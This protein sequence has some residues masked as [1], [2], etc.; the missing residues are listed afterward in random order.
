MANYKNLGIG[1]KNVRFVPMVV[2]GAESS[3]TGWRVVDHTDGIAGGDFE[4]G[5]FAIYFGVHI[6]KSTIYD[7]I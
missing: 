4:P 3:C 7:V 1:S 5:D 2:V 6:Y